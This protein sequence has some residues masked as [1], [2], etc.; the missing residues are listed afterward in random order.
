MFPVRVSP[1][2]VQLDVV[3]WSCSCCRLNTLR[4]KTYGQLSS[5]V[6]GDGKLGVVV[7]LCLVGS[8]GASGGQDWFLHCGVISSESGEGDP[9]V[10]SCL[11]LA[12]SSSTISLK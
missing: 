1:R 6:S 10:S 4:W 7:P 9:S 12:C 11:S 2:S 8:L 3:T 5:V